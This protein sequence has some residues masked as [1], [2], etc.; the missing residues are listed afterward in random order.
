MSKWFCLEERGRFRPRSFLGSSG[1]SVVNAYAFAYQPGANG[2]E[3]HAVFVPPVLPALSQEFAPSGR[4]LDRRNCAVFHCSCF[5]APYD[6]LLPWRRPALPGGGFIC[7]RIV[8]GGNGACADL[9]RMKN[10]GSVHLLR[11]SGRKIFA[12][13]IDWQGFVPGFIAAR[14]KVHRHLPVLSCVNSF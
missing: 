5:A 4:Q 9:C 1:F 6:R 7:K 11:K 8:S 12:Q 13:T 2:V 14:R 3:N 10:S